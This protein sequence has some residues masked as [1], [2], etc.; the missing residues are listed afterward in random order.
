MLSP[1]VT[2]FIYIVG[3]LIAIATAASILDIKSLYFDSKEGHE[4]DHH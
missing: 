1:G 2:T 3:S 4:E